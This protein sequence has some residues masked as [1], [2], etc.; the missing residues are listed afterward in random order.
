MPGVREALRGSLDQVHLTLD[1]LVDGLVSDL[2]VLRDVPPAD[3]HAPAEPVAVP[4]AAASSA[5]GATPPEAVL[6]G[7]DDR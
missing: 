2:A 4:R 7:R 3:P 1:P 5:A 6:A